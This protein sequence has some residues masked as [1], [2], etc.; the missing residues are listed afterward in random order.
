MECSLRQRWP[1]LYMTWNMLAR[2]QEPWLPLS[3]NVAKNSMTL[4][5]QLNFIATDLPLQDNVC[6][7]VY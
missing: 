4:E 3:G 7:L 1:L 5:V 2:S 6:V